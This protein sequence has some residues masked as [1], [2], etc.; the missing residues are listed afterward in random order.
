M[1]EKREAGDGATVVGMNT[2]N[3]ARAESPANNMQGA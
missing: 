1:V 2:D 3:E